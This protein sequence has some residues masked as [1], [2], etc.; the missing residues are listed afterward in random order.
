MWYD[1]GEK[2]LEEIAFERVGAKE[3]DRD[4]GAP[5]ERA[6]DPAKLASDDGERRQPEAHHQDKPAFRRNAPPEASEK[7]RHADRPRAAHDDDVREH[8]GRVGKP[9]RLARAGIRRGGKDEEQDD[10]RHREEDCDRHGH[11]EERRL[12]HLAVPEPRAGGQPGH[13]AE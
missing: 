13:P 4:V 11:R 9:H 5:D 12:K 2:G 10:R 3:L 6:H 7:K 8:H 1:L